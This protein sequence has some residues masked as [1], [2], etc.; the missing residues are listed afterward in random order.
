MA[1]YGSVWITPTF[2]SGNTTRAAPLQTEPT[3][4]SGGNAPLV[5]NK[6]DYSRHGRHFNKNYIFV[7]NACF[8]VHVVSCTEGSLCFCDQ[9]HANLC[10]NRPVP[11]ALEDTRGVVSVSTSHLYHTLSPEHKRHTC[12]R[13]A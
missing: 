8:C 10:H 4:T 13:G 9:E 12:T 2:D 11:V 1:Q 7:R 3:H 6:P 5:I